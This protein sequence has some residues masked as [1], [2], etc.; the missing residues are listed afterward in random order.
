MVTI[1][2]G[3]HNDTKSAV[4]QSSPVPAVGPRNPHCPQPTDGLLILARRLQRERAHGAP[5]PL[6]RHKRGADRLIGTILNSQ[7]TSAPRLVLDWSQV[8]CPGSMAELRACFDRPRPTNKHPMQIASARLR[9]TR[10]RE[11]LERM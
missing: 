11:P 2:G 7:G 6:G 5:D 4:S 9:V 3:F 8:L 10:S 1:E